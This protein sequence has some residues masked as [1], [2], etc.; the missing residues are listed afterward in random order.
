[1][2]E[3]IHRRRT[4]GWRMPPGAVYVGRPGYWRNP[5]KVGEPVGDADG[6]GIVRDRAH[7]VE[8]YRAYLER[9]PTV[10]EDVRSALA[11]RDLACWCPP[12]EP[13]HADVLL[14]LANST[15]EAP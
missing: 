7:A 10:A 12:D 6:G 14:E 2:P 11:G 13:C 1:M 8:L 9:V 5:F 15:G 3:R 4:R